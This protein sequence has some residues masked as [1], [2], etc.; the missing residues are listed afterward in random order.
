MNKPTVT[1]TATENRHHESQLC[2][3]ALLTRHFQR[4]MRSNGALLF[5]ETLAFFQC[6]LQQVWPRIARTEIRVQLLWIGIRL[7][8]RGQAISSEKLYEQ[9]AAEAQAL[10]SSSKDECEA[11]SESQTNGASAA[12]FGDGRLGGGSA[13]GSVSSSRVGNQA[14][15]R[16]SVETLVAVA[17]CAVALAQLQPQLGSRI[18]DVCEQ[19]TRRVAAITTAES[20]ESHACVS[21][22]QV[23]RFASIQWDG[24]VTDA[25]T[26]VV[27]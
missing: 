11:T 4:A 19:L 20:L 22:Q 8:A 15:H 26:A 12:A 14:K 5:R 10:F 6:D 18:Q 17:E 16:V 25:P 23:K 2:Y 7:A 3:V 9:L 24:C 27:C 21:R 13:G 1:T